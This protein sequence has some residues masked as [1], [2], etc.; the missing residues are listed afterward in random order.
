[1]HLCV[2]VHAPVYSSSHINIRKQFARV[3][4]LLLWCESQESSHQAHWWAPYMISHL[5]C[6]VWVL[7]WVC[8]HQ[9]VNYRHTAYFINS[10]L[11][12]ICMCQSSTISPRILQDLCS[13]LPFLLFSS[14][15]HDSHLALCANWQSSRVLTMRSPRRTSTKQERAV[16][17][18]LPSL[19]VA[20]FIL[21]SQGTGLTPSPCSFRPMWSQI[22]A[23][24]IPWV[25]YYILCHHLNTA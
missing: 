20:F 8:Q 22:L 16:I 14:I 18:S 12:V 3:S 1:M 2:S 6:P 25:L 19:E 15:L 7:T 24:V 5:A 4:S 17:W 11:R 9:Y 10:I 13:F 21:V 23:I